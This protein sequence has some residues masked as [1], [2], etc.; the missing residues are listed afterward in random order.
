MG[1]TLGGGAGGAGGNMNSHH[2]ISPR[3]GIL[4]NSQ[5]K[6]DDRAQMMQADEAT[7]SISQ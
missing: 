2:G 7:N 6:P 3:I 5:Y 1:S 4:G